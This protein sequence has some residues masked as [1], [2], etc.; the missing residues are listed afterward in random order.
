[1]TVCSL[2]CS[3]HIEAGA[4]ENDAHVDAGIVF[5]LEKGENE[6]QSRMENLDPE[7]QSELIG[8]AES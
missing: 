8:G 3:S 5:I 2:S 7:L 4:E 1:M 6:M